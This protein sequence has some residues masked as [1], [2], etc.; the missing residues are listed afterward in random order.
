MIK[1][2]ITAYST[3][4]FL[5][6]SSAEQDI[7]SKTSIYN[8]VNARYSDFKSI[9]V[10][11]Y[12]DIVKEFSYLSQEEQASMVGILKGYNK[13]G[14]YLKLKPS[15]ALN[16]ALI[17]MLRQKEEQKKLFESDRRSSKTD[18]RRIPDRRR[19]SDRRKSI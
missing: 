9:K 8:I 5:A 12:S 4:K 17:E 2:I 13:D 16:A 11:E 18:R 19:I 6:Y 15:A 14:Q 7:A 3:R 10:E 1:S